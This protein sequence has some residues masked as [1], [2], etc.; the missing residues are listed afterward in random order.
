MATISFYAGQFDASGTYGT[1]QIADLAGSGLGF[2]GGGFGESVAVG[3][4]QDK[5]LFRLHK[6]RHVKPV[7]SLKMTAQHLKR[8][9]H[10]SK[11]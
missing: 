1:F 2:Y 7:K 3:Q 8:S 6:P 5:K 11:T 9:L 10:I 4:A